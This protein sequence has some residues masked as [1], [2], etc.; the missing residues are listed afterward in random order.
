MDEAID[1]IEEFTTIYLS[2]G[3]YSIK[4][5]IKKRGL[6]FERLDNHKQVFIVGNEGPTISIDLAHDDFVVFKKIVFLHSGASVT[7]KFREAAPYEPKYTT[8]AGSKLIKEFEIDRKM[9]CLFMVESGG[10]ILRDCTL[11]LNSLPKHLK[12]KYACIVTMPKSFINMTSCEVIGNQHNNCSAG[13]FV[14]SHV[15][16]SDSEFRNFKSGAIYSLGRPHS[17]VCI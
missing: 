16:I 7:R 6:I 14:N 9:D 5:T 8:E 15:F 1:S 17:M 13:I 3:V 12:S 4:N 2:E 10:V 11:S